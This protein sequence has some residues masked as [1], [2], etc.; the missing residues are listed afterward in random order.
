MGIGSVLVEQMIIH[1]A[2]KHWTRERVK[3][4]KD[5]T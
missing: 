5:T 3:P 2:I 1:D 4:N